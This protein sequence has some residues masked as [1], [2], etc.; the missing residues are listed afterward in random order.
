VVLFQNRSFRKGQLREHLVVLHLGANLA[1]AGLRE[2][3]LKLEHFE[4]GGEAVLEFLGLGFQRLLG[5]DSRLVRRT[6]LA[7][8]WTRRD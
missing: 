3:L 6:D 1:G 7:E 4:T 5:V 2:D 8:T